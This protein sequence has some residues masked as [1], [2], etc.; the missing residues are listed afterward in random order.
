MILAPASGLL[1]A[2]SARSAIKPG[3]SCSA[4]RISFRPNSP[5]ERSLTLKGSRP[6]SR[7]AWK[8]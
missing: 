2:Y 4:S 1:P 3:I 5:S 8:G 6:P 7:A